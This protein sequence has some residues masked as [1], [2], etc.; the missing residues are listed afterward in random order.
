MGNEEKNALQ[1]YFNKKLLQ[2]NIFIYC[3]EKKN[4]QNS[5]PNFFFQKY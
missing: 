4:F 2:V 3:T 5:L 1:N